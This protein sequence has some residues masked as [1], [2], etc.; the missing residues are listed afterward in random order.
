MNML[1][2]AQ[3]LEIMPNA[4]KDRAAQFLPHINSAMLEF[5]IATPARQAAFLAQIAHESGSLRYVREIADGSAYDTRADL[6]NTRAEAVRLARENGT[7]PGRMYRG[8]GLIQITG[9][10]NYRACSQGLLGDPD[11][12]CEHPDMLEMPTLAV[13]SAAWY[14]DSRRLNAFADAGQFETITRKI[15]GGLNG[16]ADR[17]QYFERAKRV[18]AD[19]GPAVAPAPF[20]QP[21]QNQGIQKWLHSFLQL[22]RHS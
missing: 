7:T 19:G 20:P 12:L 13:R 5:A 15:N 14:W 16:Q 17:L 3:L 22:F 6:G 21:N 18:L 10:D 2:L 4:G 9:Y 11:M 8:R 1:T